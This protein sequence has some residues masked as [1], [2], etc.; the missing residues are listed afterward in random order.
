MNQAFGIQVAISFQ[1]LSSDWHR[2][3]S[4]IVDAANHM[5]LEENFVVL[6]ASNTFEW[7]LV[8][9]RNEFGCC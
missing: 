6:G 7:S 9:S 3:A 2:D 1:S 4:L 8:L 5:C